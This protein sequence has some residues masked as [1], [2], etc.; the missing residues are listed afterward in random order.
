MALI[1]FWISSTENDGLTTEE[2]ATFASGPKRS[3]SACAVFASSSGS[4]SVVRTST[5]PA[6]PCGVASE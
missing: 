2:L 5:P 3:C 1:A 6:T 4:I